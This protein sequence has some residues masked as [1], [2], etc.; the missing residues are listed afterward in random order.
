LGNFP[1]GVPFEETAVG[2]L[3]GALAPLGRPFGL[4]G[5]ML[6]SLLFALP[7]KEIVVSSLAMTYGLQSTLMDSEAILDHLA[8]IW[9]PLTAFCYIAFFM[10]YQPC[11]VT[12]WATWKETRSLKWVLLSMFI[13]LVAATTIT[14]AVYQG[15]KLLGF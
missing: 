8:S 1:R 5:E 9:T 14:L 12:V 11:L 4:N 3:V 2:E 7:A 15:G 6:T 13:P 10:L